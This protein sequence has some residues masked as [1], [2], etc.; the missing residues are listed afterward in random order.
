MNWWENYRFVGDVL[1]LSRFTEEEFT[2]R[3]PYDIQMDVNKITI[4]EAAEWSKYFDKHGVWPTARQWKL[5]REI[6]AWQM[7]DFEK[8]LLSCD[9]EEHY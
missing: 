2:S 7:E 8:M 3:I 5:A 4:A 6:K 1:Y 9:E